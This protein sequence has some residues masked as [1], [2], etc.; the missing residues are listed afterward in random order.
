MKNVFNKNKIDIVV[1]LA[2][3]AGVRDSLRVPEKY[4]NYNILGFLNILELSK[5]YS[6]KHLIYASTSSVYGLNYKNPFSVKDTTDHPQQFYAVTKKTNELMAHAWC[7]LYNIKATGLRFFTVY[8]PYGRP[9]IWHFLN[10]Q[11]I[12][13]KISN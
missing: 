6:I 1:N 11:K 9:D 4:L 3:Q 7:S 13:M 12:F 2:A 10:L 5:N 8:G